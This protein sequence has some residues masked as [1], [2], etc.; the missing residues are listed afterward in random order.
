MSGPTGPLLWGS[1]A[2]VQVILSEIET[3]LKLMLGS[4]LVEKKKLKNV[5]FNFLSGRGLW[6]WDQKE[7]V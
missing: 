2:T 1:M 4:F 6:K 7:R 5:K 3:K